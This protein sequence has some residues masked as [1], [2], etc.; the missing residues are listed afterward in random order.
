M[1]TLLTKDQAPGWASPEGVALEPAA[2]Q[3]LDAAALKA[4]Y[5]YW[6]A[7]AAGRIGPKRADIDLRDMAALLPHLH[8]YDVVDGGRSFY[9]RVVGTALVATI[10]TDHSKLSLTDADPDLP[11]KR[12]IAIMRIAV[13]AK[14]GV[15]STSPRVAAVKPSVHAV[16][17][18]WLPLS[19]DGVTVSQILACSIMSEPADLR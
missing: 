18:L 19:E 16:E 17:S 12:A 13:A 7:R 4:F 8:F 3:N 5:A 2:A 14:V 11:A 15:R 1:P 10:G 6:S 9:V